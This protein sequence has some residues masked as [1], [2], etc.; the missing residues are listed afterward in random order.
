VVSLL[1]F[2]RGREQAVSDG[3]GDGGGDEV[4]VALDRG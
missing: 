2:Q 4:G 1:D 3:S